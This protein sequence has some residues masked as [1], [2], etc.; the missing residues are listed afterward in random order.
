M[1]RAYY[2]A[3]CFAILFFLLSIPTAVAQPI[4]V[5]IK[6]DLI[7]LQAVDSRTVQISYLLYKKTDN[8][9]A[10]IDPGFH[11][12]GSFR[13]VDT[14]NNHIHI[15]GDLYSIDITVSPLTISFFSS[16]HRLLFS[17]VADSGIT[18]YDC[19]AKLIPSEYYGLINHTWQFA[20]YAEPLHVHSGDQGNASGLF[21]WSP[22]GIGLLADVDDAIASINGSSGDFEYSKIE[23][24]RKNNVLYL[25]S[26]TPREIFTSISNILG[27]PHLPPLWSLGFLHSKW[28]QDEKEVFTKVDLYRSKDIPVDAFILD[29]EWMDWGKPWGEFKWNPGTFPSAQSGKFADSLEDFGITLMGIRKPRIHLYEP[30]G[31]YAR[32]NGYILH[33]TE[34]TDYMSK[35]VVGLV[36]YF[37]PE[38]RK[39]FWN[40]YI[41]SSRDPYKRG[42]KGFW[43]DEAGYK[44]SLY[45]MYMQRTQYEGQRSYNNERVFSLNRNYFVGSNRYAYGLWSGDIPSSFIS[46]SEQR[47]SLLTSSMMGAGWWSMD[48]GGFL[49]IES[50][51]PMISEMYIRWMQMG[52]FVPFYRIHSILR[53]QREPWLY[54]ADAERISANFI[55]LRYTLLP[56]IYDS[57]HQ[58]T[59][60]GIPPVRPLVFDYP[61]E[62]QTIYENRAWL[63][64]DNILV[65]PNVHYKARSVTFYLPQGNW[66]NYWNDAMI[67]GGGEVTISSELDQIPIFIKEGAIIP[68]RQY[69]RFSTDDLAFRSIEFH[70]YAG[71][72]ASTTFYEDDFKTYDYEKG[73]FASIPY[74]HY[75]SALSEKITIGPGETVYKPEARSGFFIFHLLEQFPTDVVYNGVRLVETNLNSIKK[76]AFESWARDTI[77][78]LVIVHVAN[79]FNEGEIELISSPVLPVTLGGSLDAPTV[80]VFP[81]PAI[82]DITCLIDL[83]TADE[84]SIRLI[85]LL[86]REFFTS[87]STLH[88]G[89]NQLVI[90]TGIMPS[91]TYYLQVNASNLQV[92]KQVVVSK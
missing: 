50:T 35:K 74:H 23:S 71:A 86:G 25:I 90:P 26:G 9:S 67:A 52:V 17:S 55:R 7:E 91:G 31:I 10:I 15:E 21:L 78:G 41:D 70:V 14:S 83:P 53:F 69:G 77:N 6:D 64:G 13:S 75:H 5:G 84:I 27:K 1:V 39:W 81:N 40:S 92:V 3:S 48:V 82:H 76:S 60:D 8:P 18:D 28:G 43:N 11:A 47:T 49:G 87:K 38:A 85:D 19:H 65:A 61:N 4:R 89:N 29:F 12:H 36:D 16:D 66:I 42:I 79:P 57:F 56:Y 88:L 51:D 68:E 34:D 44:R 62:S 32:D 58:Y 33:G 59:V 73:I 30:E 22:K 37:N 72:E 24:Q 63:F 20:R 80:S 2:Q 46:L 45:S 54:G